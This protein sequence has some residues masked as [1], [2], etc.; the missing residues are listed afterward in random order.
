MD[1]QWLV[2]KTNPEYINYF[3]KKNAVSTIL[4]QILINRGLKTPEEVRSFLK[5]DSTQMS[6][7]FELPDM[8][9]AVQRI[10]TA[11]E[12][13]EKVLVHG[14]YDADGLTATTIVVKALKMLGIECDFFIPNRMVHGYGFTVASVQEAKSRGASLIIT[15]DCGITSF[16]AVSQ[17]KNEG[18]DVIITD[19][20][21]PKKIQP[22]TPKSATTKTVQTQPHEFSLPE[23]FAVV[24]PKTAIHSPAVN[25]SGAGVALKLAQALLIDHGSE[26]IMS[27]FFDLAALGTIADVVPLTGENRM[28]VK[29]GLDM[30]GHG[31]NTGLL[32]LKNV[33]GIKGK[34]LKPGRLLFS[35]IP[36]INAPGRISDARS[37]ITLLSTDSEDEAMDI[38]S[39]LDQQNSERQ[40]IEETVYQEAL[41]VLEQ[42]GITPFIV[43]SAEGWHKGV[44]GIVASRIAE[45]FTRPVIILSIEG[46][47]ARG[48]AR[49]I[50]SV[51]IYDALSACRDCLSRF[52]GHKQAAGLEL[53][54]QDIPLFEDSL[55]RAVVDLLADQDFTPALH[56]DA[57]IDLSDVS[58][59]LLKEFVLL[60]PFGTGNPE[61]LLGSKNLEAIDPRVVGNGHLK[62]KLKQKQNA[63]DTIGFNMA[64]YMSTLESSYKIDVVFTPFI[65]EWNGSK[66]LNLNLKALRPSIEG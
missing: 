13:G 44:I 27:R 43:L 26:D 23:A 54:S 2:N 31:T 11:S 38:A 21:E 17:G 62:M 4:A 45:T 52:G 66:Q 56:I 58:F 25:L 5:P 65:N 28:I 12:R 20:H 59:R 10:R 42:K 50:P 24:N 37:V 32:A 46:D 63:L 49:S 51:D 1:R 40:R 41:T 3:A 39:W 7:P 19:H 55:N 64:S 16:E 14:D 53:R 57:H 47:T 48:S 22:S 6:D 34:Y 9:K 35:V 8:Q 33:A 36:R 15:V 29:E 60:E 30:I 61:P 18:I